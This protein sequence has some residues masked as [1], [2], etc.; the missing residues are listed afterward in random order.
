MS[1]FKY[2]RLLTFLAAAAGLFFSGQGK[3]LWVLFLTLFA[4]YLFVDVFNADRAR[5]ESSADQPGVPDAQTG[6]I[7][8]YRHDGEEVFGAFVILNGWRVLIDIKDDK[9][10]EDRIA[11]ARLLI[12]EL[13]NLEAG[14][15]DFFQ[16]NPEFSG[17]RVACIGLHSKRLTQAEVFWEPEGYSVLEGEDFRAP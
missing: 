14:L 5:V 4:F 9:L 15:R 7:G 12:S 8:R 1:V 16:R 3:L 10:V 11:H 6:V 17:K 2:V 13:R